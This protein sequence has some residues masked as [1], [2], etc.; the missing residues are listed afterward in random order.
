MRPELPARIVVLAES[1]GVVEARVVAL[2]DPAAL[3]PQIQ[4]FGNQ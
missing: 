4:L 1:V 3:R 2:D